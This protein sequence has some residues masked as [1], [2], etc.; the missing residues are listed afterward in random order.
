MHTAPLRKDA[1]RSRASILLA[2]EE[3]LAGTP[4]ASF[5]ELSIAAGVS[6]A[7][8]YRHFTDRPS[9]LIAL[10][11]RSLEEIEA[12]VGGWEIGPSSF[13]DLLTLMADQQARYQGVLSA[14]RS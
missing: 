3:L 1:A 12:E 8:V 11:E 6:Q 4:A 10:L 5:A 9:L 14:V 7:T 13:E 2:A